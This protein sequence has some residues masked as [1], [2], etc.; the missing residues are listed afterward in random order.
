LLFHRVSEPKVVKN[1]VHL[2]VRVAPGE[3][4]ETTQA[5]VDAE[6]RRLIGFGATTG[7]TLG[8]TQFR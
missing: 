1:R 6:A 8:A 2:D 4:K 3:A 5:L 7:S